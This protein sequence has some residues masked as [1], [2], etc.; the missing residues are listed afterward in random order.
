VDPFD[1]KTTKGIDGLRAEDF[2]AKLDHT[3]VPIVS[4]TQRFNGR[5]L[6]LLEISGTAEDPTLADRAN[7]LANLA[8]QAPT[9]R[10]VAFG[11]FAERAIFMKG[12]S[13]DPQERRSSINEIMAQSK[14]LGKQTAVYD[15]LHDALTLFGP[16]QPGDTIL[17]I[18]DG[19]DNH[20]KRNGGD[21]EKEFLARGT[22]LL[23]MMRPRASMVPEPGQQFRW[24]P[25]A[26]MGVR[27][28]AGRSDL[29]RLS[30]RTGGAY[31]GFNPHFF[32]FAWA[33]YMVGITAPANLEK[34]KEWNLRLHGAAAKAHPDALI[35][36]P[37]ELPLCNPVQ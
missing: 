14:S 2:E 34:P 7:Q 10:S 13:S 24:K 37:W 15:A 17:L 28:S 35:Y 9:G 6:L 5:L 4:V 20:S 25:D 12:F 30:G 31:T 29:A 33:G 32:E 16:H 27:T 1:S 22:R 8:A 3:S 36:Q 23:V 21:M 18:S 19:F 11:V 26:E